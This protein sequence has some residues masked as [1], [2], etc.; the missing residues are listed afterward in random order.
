MSD[1]DFDELDRAVNSALGDTAAHD[2]MSATASASEVEETDSVEVKRSSPSISS[3]AVHTR[4]MPKSDAAP[5][6]A[7]LS[8]AA[9]SSV[10]PADTDIEMPDAP[11]ASAKRVIPHREGRFMDVVHPTSMVR[12]IGAPVGVGIDATSVVEE[13]GIQSHG[14]PKAESVD[15]PVEPAIN[16]S[17]DASLVNEDSSSV[18]AEL[19]GVDIPAE[20]IDVTAGNVNP[21]SIL[22]TPLD[23]LSPLAD[24]PFL[25]DAK[26]EKRPLGTGDV[27]PYEMPTPSLEPTEAVAEPEPAAVEPVIETPEED[28]PLPDELQG[29][30]LAIE[31]ATVETTRDAVSGDEQ[32]A[33][34]TGPTS[35]ARQYK[36]TIKTVSEDDT[37]AAIFDPQTYHQPIEEPAKKSFHWG[38]FIALIVILLIAV[39]VAVA[40]VMGGILPVPL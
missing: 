38:W 23:E 30:L 28:A 1:I 32:L 6:R 26:V 19:V 14:A 40:A 4:I 34:A 8:R 5:H 10:S 33:V 18:D 37:S 20:S 3:H 24:S 25:P 11:S 21:G 31:S 7:S 15:S 2:A 27:T 35:I 29:D 13:G 9:P 17:V 36:E 39:V 22:D 16:Q 12:P